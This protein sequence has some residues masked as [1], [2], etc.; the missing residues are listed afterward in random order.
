MGRQTDSIMRDGIRDGTDTTDLPPFV[1]HQGVL[2][3][4]SDLYWELLEDFEKACNKLLL[5]KEQHLVVDLTPVI[6]ISSSFLGCL[7]NLVLKASRLKKRV[8]VRVTLDVSW[9]FDI[10]GGRRN[11]VMEI[12]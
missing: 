8:K 9:L 6:F 7:N 12:V 3:A 1:V 2:K 11:M 4:K 5:S 10:M